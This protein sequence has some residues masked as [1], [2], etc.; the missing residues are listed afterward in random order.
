M[1]T[2]PKSIV[3]PRWELIKVTSY[4]LKSVPVISQYVMKYG[5][6]TETYMHN[7]EKSFI[8]RC[9]TFNVS[10][11][12]SFQCVH[13][14]DLADCNVEIITDRDQVNAFKLL[15]NK[16][17]DGIIDILY[18]I[19]RSWELYW[20]D[21]NLLGD[22]DSDDTDVDNDNNNRAKRIHLGL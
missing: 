11:G 8:V 5:E 22:A 19:R 13:E 4:P 9:H 12:V 3:D 18:I 14:I 17:V 1:T 16:N 6:F 2:E 21:N 20:E 15:H 10:H 7:F